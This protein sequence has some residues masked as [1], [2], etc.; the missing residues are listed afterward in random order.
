MAT[1]TQTK[2][3][4]D[5]G[6]AL[7]WTARFIW[8]TTLLLVK[9]ALILFAALAAALLRG[10]VSNDELREE[11]RVSDQAFDRDSA[12]NKYAPYE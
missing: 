5:W 1:V 7:R 12:V 4:I 8:A 10:R 6:K 3:G 11:Y 9:L 2:A